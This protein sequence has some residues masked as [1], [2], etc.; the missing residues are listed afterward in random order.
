MY[1]VSLKPETLIYV[2]ENKSLAGKEEKATEGEASGRKLV[3]TF[4]EDCEDGLVHRVDRE[5]C[6]LRP[7]LL[8]IAEILQILGCALPPDPERTTATTELLLEAHYQH[9][10]IVCCTCTLDTENHEVHVYSISDEVDAEEAMALELTPETRTKMVL[11]RSLQ[12]AE[13]LGPDEPLERVWASPLATLQARCEALFPVPAAAA[14][15]AGGR[16]RRGG[17]GRGRARG[18][19]PGGG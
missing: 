19:A 12:R 2:S 18:R 4:F 8:N 6:T 11:A 16:G 14:L 9:L 15:P 13:A 17:R 7:Q 10:H 1:R 5:G 3:V